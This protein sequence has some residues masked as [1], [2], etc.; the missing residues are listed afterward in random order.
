MLGIDNV[1]NRAV[2]Q[3]GTSFQ[4]R[5]IGGDETHRGDFPWTVALEMSWGFQ[6]CGGA[7]INEK[8]HSFHSFAKS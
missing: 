8:V 1:V 7:L 2:P 4:D 5:I 3:C 6:F